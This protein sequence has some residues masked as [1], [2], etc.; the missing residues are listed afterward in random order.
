[1]DFVDFLTLADEA[2]L[3][4]VGIGGHPRSSVVEFNSGGAFHI[5]PAALAPG[6]L[7]PGRSRRNDGRRGDG[8]AVLE[9]DAAEDDFDVLEGL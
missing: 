2:L 7:F 6:L 1:M 5:K 3:C 8:G 4:S 9:D